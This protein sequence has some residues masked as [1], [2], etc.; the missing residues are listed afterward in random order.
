VPDA[1]GAS[2]SKRSSCSS[3]F[4]PSKALADEILEFGRRSLPS[5]KYRAASTSSPSCRARRPE[6]STQQ[7]ARA[8]LERSRTT[9]LKLR[10]R[11]NHVSSRELDNRFGSLPRRTPRLGLQKNFPPALKASKS[12]M[13]P[14]AGSPGGDDFARWK[15]AWP[16]RVWGTPTYPKQYGGGGLTTAQAARAAA[17]DERSSAP[18]RRSAAWA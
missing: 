6:N 11:R 13:L 8:L 14:T 3:R 7:S 17:G 10:H 15:K 12:M 5:F 1:E 4:A 18:G 2:R 16:R 9:N